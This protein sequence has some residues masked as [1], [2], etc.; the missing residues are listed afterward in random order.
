MSST[1][2]C[3][4][5]TPVEAP[6]QQPS[7]SSHPDAQ[8]TRETH[9]PDLR[10]KRGTKWQTLI[11]YLSG[12]QGGSGG[13]GGLQAGAGGTGEGP[14]L[15][16]DIKAERIIMKTFNNSEATPSDFLRIPLGNIDLRSE[17]RVNPARRVVW[18][19]RER[20]CVRRMYS[21]R[22]VGHTEPLTV[23]LYQGHSAEEEWKRHLARHSRL[24]HPHILQIYASASS[25]GIHATIF[26]DDLVLFSE[27]LDSFRDSVVLRA[28]IHW[29]TDVDRDNA[30][31]Y[32]ASS[33]D[34]RSSI[35]IIHVLPLTG[36]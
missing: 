23:A 28:Y 20:K 26:H 10:A 15:Q 21:A 19:H 3:A 2:F 4:E 35:I 1:T 7:V 9:Q 12:G 11:N 36:G 17:I 8:A 22:V 18:R 25:S 14:A 6:L 30:Y 34:L 24:R 31:E 16:Y 29:Y 5:S 27:F 32:Y 13:G 33:Q